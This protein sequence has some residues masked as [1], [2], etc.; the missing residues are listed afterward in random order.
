M[1]DKEIKRVKK[2]AME[3]KEKAAKIIKRSNQPIM[4]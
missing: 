3:I 1:E 4:L 2:E